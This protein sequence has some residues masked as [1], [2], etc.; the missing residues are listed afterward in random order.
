[1][2]EVIAISLASFFSIMFLGLNSQYVRDQ[3]VGIA[4]V[5]S[6]F[7]HTSQFV[8]TRIAANTELLVYAFFGSGLGS[9]IGIC[10]SILIYKYLQK[11]K[12]R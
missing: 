1:M 9:S 4:F 7:I 12:M 6:W 5:L 11:R 8:Y 10:S 3:R 2:W